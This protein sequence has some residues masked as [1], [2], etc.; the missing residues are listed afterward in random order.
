MDLRIDGK[1]A[2]VCGSSQGIG[3]SIAAELARLGASVT[4]LARDQQ[5]LSAVRAELAGPGPH[6]VVTADF[7][8][9][10]E[11]EA[12][13]REIVGHGPVEIL[14]N[15]SGG[16]PG[17]PA[18]DAS[19]DDYST[20][21]RRHIIANQTLLQAFLPGM[22]AAGYGR[23]IN[24]ISTSVYEPIPNLGVSNTIR[25][26]VA[27]WAKTLAKELGPYGITVNNLL[28]GF[29]ETARLDKIV[30]ARAA[31]ESKSRDSVVEAIKASVPARRFGQPEELGY[32]AAFLASKAAS[33]ISGVSLPVD[34]GRLNS[35]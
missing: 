13:A 9:T 19:P 1:R 16:P 34:G 30:E 31:R 27:S 24:I 25:G 7:D 3:R 4:L 22:K 12:A 11:V 10:E 8:Q 2:V 29:T 6:R 5:A 35:I 14:V 15:N 23:V 18:A 26:A 32:A 17:G 28:P 33:Y 20:A 21:F